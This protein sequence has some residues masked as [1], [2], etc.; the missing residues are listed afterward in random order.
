APSHLQLVRADAQHPGVDPDRLGLAQSGRLSPGM[1]GGTGAAG[2]Y[3]VGEHRGQVVFPPKPPQTRR[4]T[5]EGSDV[6]STFR[7]Q[8][9]VPRQR[10]QAAPISAPAPPPVIVGAPREVPRATVFDIRD[11]SVTYGTK[12][13]LDW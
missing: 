4:M 10:I 8:D 3:P 7:D 6:S 9:A 2:A 12:K 13:A 1:G 5:E 11:M